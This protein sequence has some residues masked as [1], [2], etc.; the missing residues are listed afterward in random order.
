M[1]NCDIE[2]LHYITICISQFGIFTHCPIRI[3]I[4]YSKSNLFF[5][6]QECK[7]LQILIMGSKLHQIL[8]S[9]A[10][11]KEETIKKIK[12]CLEQ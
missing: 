6:P 2:G 9:P 8:V 11:D 5:C 3:T 7:E 12:S 1:N 4:S 10:N